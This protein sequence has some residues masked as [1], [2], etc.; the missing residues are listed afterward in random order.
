MKGENSTTVKQA[1]LLREPDWEVEIRIPGK[2]PIVLKPSSGKPKVTLC[3]R[4]QVVRDAFEEK[5]TETE[6]QEAHEWHQAAQEAEGV[7]K[8]LKC[9][10]AKPP[11]PR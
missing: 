9:G 5:A 11:R 7:A 10:W 2:A 6:G 1:E 3:D 4:L 8:D